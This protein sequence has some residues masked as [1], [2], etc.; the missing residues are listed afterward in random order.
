MSKNAFIPAAAFA[1]WQ[2]SSKPDRYEWL[3]NA[4]A[5]LNK[6]SNLPNAL[7]IFLF[8]FFFLPTFF[9]QSKQ[10]SLCL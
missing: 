9:E 5:S 1:A 10:T 8:T 3:P 7:F 6:F 4:L 2:V